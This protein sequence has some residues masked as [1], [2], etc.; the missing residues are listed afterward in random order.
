MA[1]KAAKK[2]ATKATTRSAKKAAPA[3]T[4]GHASTKVQKMVSDDMFPERDPKIEAR[5][6]EYL[7]A[8]T[9]AEKAIAEAEDRE[10]TA[11]AALKESVRAAG[12][13]SYSSYDIRYVVELK[14]LDDRLK[15]RRV[16]KKEASPCTQA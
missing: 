3:E 5:I 1:T 14:K 4:N 2:P 7:E 9:S 6:T 16:K 13:D 15:V 12:L 10:K 11:H 8:Q